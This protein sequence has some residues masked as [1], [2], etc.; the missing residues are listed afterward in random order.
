MESITIVIV[1]TIIGAILA[2]MFV[3][4]WKIIEKKEWTNNKKIKAIIVDVVFCVSVIIVI[5]LG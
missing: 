4:I 5:Y 3:L 2:G 1:T